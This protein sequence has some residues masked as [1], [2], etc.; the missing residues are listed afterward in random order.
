MRM[1]INTLLTICTGNIMK[2][3]NLPQMSYPL[4]YFNG[5]LL[6]HVSNI[7]ELVVT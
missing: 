3:Y 2:L 7:N 4:G 6:Q 5:V 1:K